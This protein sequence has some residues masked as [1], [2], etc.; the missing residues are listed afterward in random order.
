MIRFEAKIVGLP[1]D[2]AAMLSRLNLESGG[3][4]QQVLDNAVIRW[5]EQYTPFKTGT[6]ASS[7]YGATE[8]GSGEV[9]YPGPYARYLYYGE[10]YGPNIPIFEDNS[11]EPTGWFSPPGKKKHPTG[12]ALQYSTGVNALAGSYWFERMKADH[13]Q[14]IV[15]EVQNVVGNS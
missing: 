4:A 7:P 9:V 6:L 11:E 8:V 2:T 3:K 14:D 5:C 13:L 1:S 10:V 12:R 15:T